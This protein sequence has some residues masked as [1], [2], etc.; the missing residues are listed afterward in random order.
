MGGGVAGIE[1]YRSVEVIDRPRQVFLGQP[2][3]IVLA[4]QVLQV[5]R[6]IDRASRCQSGTFFCGDLNLDLLGNGARDL[7]LQLQDVGQVALVFT[8]P[9]MRIRRRVNQLHADPHAI[10][11]A[12]H[13]PFDDG[14]DVQRL[15]NLRSGRLAPF[16]PHHRRA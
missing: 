15:R 3:Q 6:R 1:P 10:A 14:V 12:L 13:R 2:P 5:G 11:G 9:E 7:A 16:E 4:Q 8:R